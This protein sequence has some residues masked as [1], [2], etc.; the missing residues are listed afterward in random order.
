MMND[1]EGCLGI[2]VLGFLL[3]GILWLFGFNFG[4]TSDGTV[5]YEDCRQIITLKSGSWQTYFHNFWLFA[6]SCG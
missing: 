5:K 6:D 2:L 4:V 1:G 3:A